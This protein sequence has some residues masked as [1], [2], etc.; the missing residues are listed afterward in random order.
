M[1]SSSTCSVIYVGA[2][3][4]RA[5]NLEFL[6]HIIAST[7]S[8]IHVNSR[9]SEIIYIYSHYSSLVVSQVI[10]VLLPMN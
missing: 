7:C 6:L 5:E 2:V 10:E 9:N 8:Q 1:S 4:N 3:K